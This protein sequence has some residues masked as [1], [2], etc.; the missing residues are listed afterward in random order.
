MLPITYLPGSRLDFDE[1][2]D[3][4]ASRSVIA[5]ERFTNAI[6]AALLRH[7]PEPADARVRE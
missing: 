6:D 7:I 3:W 2:F 5:A 4:Y 1:A